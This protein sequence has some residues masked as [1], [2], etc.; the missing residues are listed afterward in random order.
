MSNLCPAGTS[1][2][3][4][5]LK[6]YVQENST[7]DQCCLNLKRSKSHVFIQES[8]FSVIM[9]ELYRL[10]E[11]YSTNE[12]YEI[13]VNINTAEYGLGDILGFY[14]S[15]VCVN[16]YRGHD[17]PGLRCWAH[18]KLGSIRPLGWCTIVGHPA[19]FNKNHEFFKKSP[20][21]RKRVITQQHSIF[22]VLHPFIDTEQNPF[23][24]GNNFY[25]LI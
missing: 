5:G 6:P 12:P 9:D 25:T 13:L 18:P 3:K 7:L 16:Y 22:P 24:K 15:W 10:T 14:G 23:T 8:A 17:K 21:E 11:S 1:S 2:T 19:A 4:V 20:Q